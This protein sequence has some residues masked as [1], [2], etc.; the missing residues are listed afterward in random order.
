VPIRPVPSQAEPAP[1]EGEF[2][3]S[4]LSDPDDDE[5]D[6][7]L[8]EEEVEPQV[9]A[10]PLPPEPEPPRRRGRPRKTQ[11]PKPVGVGA[12]IA[13][14]KNFWK[15]R[16][17]ET[18]WPDVLEQIRHL[19]K[20]PW[21]V[22]VRVKQTQPIEMIIG[23]PF[24]GGTV[25][26]GDGRASSTQ[27]VDKIT[28]D[29]HMVSGA[30]GPTTYKI[31]I[32][33]RVSGK[34]F[35]WGTLRLASPDAI[36]GLRRHQKMQPPPQYPLPQYPP[37]Q[38]PY[39]PPYTGYGAPPPSFSS[40]PAAP[41]QSSSDDVRELHYLRG[42]LDEVMRAMREG[43]VPN[44]QPPPAVAQ[45]S[46]EEIVRRV[47]EVLR[48]T[49]AVGVGAPPPVAAAA[50]A[51]S[52]MAVTLESSVNSILTGA[53]EGVMKKVATSIEQAIRGGGVSTQ[54]NE[55]VAEIIPPDD[56]KDHLPFEGIPTGSKW[57]DGRDV[58]YPRDRETGSIN[59]MGIPFANP[60]LA[61]K[62]S[63]AAS[64]LVGN[65][66]DLVKNLGRSAIPVTAEVIPRP[67]GMGQVQAPPVHHQPP[68]APTVTPHTNGAAATTTNGGWP[69]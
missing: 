51:P 28:D 31:E 53:L 67:T 16:D 47:V 69:A 57:S 41:V 10:A 5:E 48:P 27:I 52:P 15:S 42:T 37:P 12:T 44:I 66:G 32:I 14:P 19:H 24:N 7:E 20:T 60:F 29:Y 11:D 63:D 40:P 54:P 49:P 9:A 18:L 2:D 8:E 45:P 46:V 58:V 65:V 68:P 26:G 6:E 64:S 62:F 56:P 23:Q 55:A 34:V 50:A 3:L 43:R 25:M 30:V 35:T 36:I 61:E 1:D 13:A 33:W 4:Q 17:I 21:D 39:Q 38:Y 59:Y 22:D